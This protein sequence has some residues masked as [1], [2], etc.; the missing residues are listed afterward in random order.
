MIIQNY[1]RFTDLNS[2]KNR[3][4]QLEHVITTHILN[5]NVNR[6]YSSNANKYYNIVNSSNVHIN[7]PQQQ[8]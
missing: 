5:Q 2:H 1:Y 4:H 3:F 8:Y 7:S 6:E